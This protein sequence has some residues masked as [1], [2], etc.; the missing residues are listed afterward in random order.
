ML[1]LA[2]FL[3]SNRLTYVA[4]I[5][6]TMVWAITDFIRRQRDL[7]A[8]TDTNNELDAELMSQ[9]KHLAGDLQEIVSEQTKRVNTEL[10][11]LRSLVK[12]SV[13]TLQGSLKEIN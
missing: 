9:I 10:E 8:E 11:H 5:L 13:N 4:V 2:I 6:T 1:L 7:S 3:D 12:D